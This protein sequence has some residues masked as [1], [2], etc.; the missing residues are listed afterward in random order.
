MLVAVLYS[1]S[2]AVLNAAVCVRVLGHKPY[3][4]ASR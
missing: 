1:L 4:W 3:D 2:F